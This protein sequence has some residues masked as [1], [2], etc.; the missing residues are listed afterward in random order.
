M[1]N[2]PGKFLGDVSAGYGKTLRFDLFES[3]RTVRDTDCDVILRGAGLVLCYNIPT[4]LHP[5]PGWAS[6]SVLLSET[7]TGWTNV[8]TGDRPTQA[9]MMAVLSCLQQIKILGDY[10]NRISGQPAT[11]GLDNVILDLGSG[12]LCPVRSSDV[13]STFDVDA[14]EWLAL[15]N[16]PQGDAGS[17]SPDHS[18]A[19][20]NPDGFVSMLDMRNDA[21]WTWD[22][23]AKYLGD[24]SAAHGRTL[25]FDLTENPPA[26]NVLTGC[27]VI[28]RGA[29]HVLCYD[30]GTANHPNEGW[31]SYQ[32][33][34]D[35]TDVAWTNVVTGN[36]PTEAEML[37]VLS[38]LQQLQIRADYRN[39]ISGTPATAG[40]DSV[41]LDVSD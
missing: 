21:V 25:N 36:R 5:E 30:I 12:E 20:G 16:D 33:P 19:G 39:T 4:V 23:P 15:G 13:V 32:I 29:G 37:A 1:W 27:D 18:A 2:A 7:D 38:C 28:L 14:D 17:S 35:E 41:E 34:L 24:V 10:R 6:Y 26:A 31:T 40:L 22:A 11:D 9:E 8:I 3:I